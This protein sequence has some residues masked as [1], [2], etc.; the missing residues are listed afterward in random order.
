MR[1][2]ATP[3]IYPG[4]P[5][6]TIGLKVN[7][8]ILSGQPMK[9]GWN[10]Y[11]WTVPAEAWHEG[12]NRLAVTTSHLASPAAI[13]LSSDSRSLGIAVSDLLL[14]LIKSNSHE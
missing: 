11:E 13:G 14:R 8:Q 10:I 12:F 1:V 6:I 2:R 4:A 5:P 7:S 9:S 3:F